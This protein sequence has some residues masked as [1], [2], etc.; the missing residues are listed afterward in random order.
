MLRMM[1]HLI[2]AGSN[3]SKNSEEFF[4]LATAR[5]YKRP[6]IMILPM[7]VDFESAA[8]DGP[9]RRVSNLAARV[10]F[11]VVDTMPAFR[12]DG[13]KADRYRA[14]PEDLHLNEHGNK[15]VAEALSRAI[16]NTP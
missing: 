5:S 12:A 13:E 6:M 4:Q 9:M 3:S 11:E 15:I 1:G 2:S 7:L 14:A 8:F 10:G 16:A